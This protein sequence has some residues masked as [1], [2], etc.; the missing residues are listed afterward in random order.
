MEAE[1]DATLSALNLHHYP[2]EEQST[3]SPSHIEKSSPS[4]V[5]PAHCYDDDDFEDW[6]AIPI[7]P[8]K[9]YVA[10]KFGRPKTVNP[11]DDLTKTGFTKKDPFTFFKDVGVLSIEN[12]NGKPLQTAKGRVYSVNGDISS[13]TIDAHD[14]S[15]PMV[16]T[17]FLTW[18]SVPNY[19]QAYK[20]FDADKKAKAPATFIP[21]V[22][23]LSA[24]YEDDDKC[25][26]EYAKVG[27]Y[28]D[29]VIVYGVSSLKTMDTWDLSKFP[30]TLLGNIKRANYPY[31]RQIQRTAMP[32]ILD[33][34]DLLV[35]T[36]TGS[37]KTLA[38]LVPMIARCLEAKECGTF[39]SGH[40][41]V[42]GLVISPTR[43]LTHQI[44]EQACKF[45]NS[46]GISV[47]K[48]YGEYNTLLNTKELAAGCDILICTPGRLRHLYD[49]GLLD[50]RSLDF[51][52]F[53]E[54][55]LILGD[56]FMEDI[57]PIIE[58]TTGIGN[59]R[60]Y[61]ML[62]FSATFNEATMPSATKYMHQETSASVFSKKC[63]T[64]KL[65]IQNFQRV[66]KMDK[67]QKLCEFL[68]EQYQE[69]EYDFSKF[70]HILIFVNSQSLCEE[71]GQNLVT[72][73]NCPVVS[74]SGLYTQDCRFD[75]FDSFRRGNTPIM[76]TTDL[77]ARGIDL[78][79][80]DYV[81]NYEL[82][83]DIGTYI[84]RVG[85]VGRIK[86]GQAISFVDPCQNK[87][88]VLEILQVLQVVHH[89][90]SIEF[91][92][93]VKEAKMYIERGDDF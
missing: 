51:M 4:P 61:Q 15:L 59:E 14:S 1:L 91:D 47:A 33:G 84:Y 71:L 43:E 79:E 32:L 65:C 50:F 49:A 3:P 44:Y 80:V 54:A 66:Q 29:T 35:C 46:T 86:E 74:I 8:P 12:V 5:K 62:F 55:D 16:D 39:F 31:P 85:R 24:I 83:R 64:N 40:C 7:P 78:K 9:P 6:A 25:A 42:Y 2:V 81:I 73:F 58:A 11:F 82:P 17:S 88:L 41:K 93:I 57:H 28:D 38:F 18:N 22:R 75:V 87:H 70:P 63:A 48:M 67:F 56:D 72:P 92:E 53:D 34:C 68:Q 20:A 19:P 27:Y 60:P 13:K 37:G 21:P 26:A 90:V 76:F 52:V 30:A 23:D 77:C 36:E 10:P 69:A 45:A 89:P